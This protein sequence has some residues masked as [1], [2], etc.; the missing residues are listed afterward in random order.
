MTRVAQALCT[1]AA[2]MLSDAA[3]ATEPA[4]PCPAFEVVGQGPDLVLV[5]GLGSP[6]EIWEGVREKLARAYRVHLVHVA[7]FAGR[8]PSGDPATLLERAATEILRHFQCEKV[9]RAVYAGHSLGG[10]LGLKLAIDHPE[11][12][13]R[14][15]VVDSLPFFP[16]IFDPAATPARSASQAEVMR[17]AILN[18]DAATFA[19]SQRLGVRSLVRNS[20]YHDRVVQWSL[21]SDRATFGGAVHRLMTT[22]CAL[23]SVRFERQSR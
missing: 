19:A 4:V 2:L 5:P 14:L 10:F 11:R 8:R 21:D 16:L 20:A 18:Q 7:G 3:K 17:A 15:I 9:E 13:A 6:P 12:I 23:A 22:A 1:F